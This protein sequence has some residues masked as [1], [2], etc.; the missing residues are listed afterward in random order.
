MHSS[1]I[2]VS[3]SP[4]AIEVG[5]ELIGG[6]S[7]GEV[8]EAPLAASTPGPSPTE[9]IVFHR[10]GD[11]PSVENL[12]RMTSHND[13][14]S[15]HPRERGSNAN[16]L[17]IGQVMRAV[18]SA[19]PEGMHLSREARVAFQKVATTAL[20]Y[21]ACLADDARSSR[22]K[23]KKRK[24]LTVQDVRDALEAAGLAHLIPLMHTTVKRNRE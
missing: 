18:T 15:G 7:G 5:D 24:T 13:L 17:A 20:L 11:P 21:I 16:G 14:I 23:G 8:A 10:T 12:P 2:M 3:H 6:G 22:T 1:P 4:E 19:L 9:Q